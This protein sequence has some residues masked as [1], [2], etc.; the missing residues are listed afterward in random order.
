MRKTTYTI[1]SHLGKTVADV[2]HFPEDGAEA[3]FQVPPP[4]L[5]SP[6]PKIDVTAPAPRQGLGPPRVNVDSTAAVQAGVTVNAAFLEVFSGQDGLLTVATD[7]LSQRLRSAKS[8]YW[9]ILSEV[10]QRTL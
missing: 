9:S 8:D 6:Y 4:V 1:L 5:G 7:R 10:Q 3:P 2:S